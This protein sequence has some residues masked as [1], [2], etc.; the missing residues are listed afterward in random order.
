M[1]KNDEYVSFPEFLDLQSH[2]APKPEDY[3]LGKGELE[4]KIAEK[5]QREEDKRCRYRL[6][7][8]LVHIGSMVSEV[9]SHTYDYPRKSV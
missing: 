2:L 1:K 8:V 5:G 7:A 9:L 4:G 6:Y 3:G